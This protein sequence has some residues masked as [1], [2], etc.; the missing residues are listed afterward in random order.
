MILLSDIH[1]DFLEFQNIVITPTKTN[2]LASFIIADIVN[3]SQ[4]NLNYG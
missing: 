3:L 2:Y 1:T 4:M